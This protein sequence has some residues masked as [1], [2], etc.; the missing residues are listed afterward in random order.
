MQI[1]GRLGFLEGT[2][3]I[4]VNTILFLLKLLV[5][6]RLGSVAMVADAW[7][8]LSDML[9]SFV[10]ILGFWIASTRAD[11]RHPFGHGRAELV[12]SV[13]IATLLGVVGVN[14]LHESAVRLMARKAV[15]FSL[16]ALVVFGVS[17]VVK[18]ALARFS[19]WA[20]KQ[21]NSLSLAADGW[22]HRSD[23]AA[24][25]FIVI[26]AV[27]GLKFWWMDAVL[28]IGVSLLI[29]H[30][31]FDILRSSASSLLGEAH[32][33]D[34]ENRLNAIVQKHLS[35]DSSVHHIH[36]HRYGNHSE[37]SFHVRMPSDTHLL[38]SHEKISAI[39]K[40]VNSTLS[41]EATIHTEPLSLP[42]E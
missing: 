32:D 1:A 2:V 15:A 27:L 17:A 39:E 19:F 36:V 41:M 26:G 22:H 25:L 20:G 40:D 38:E 16:Q 42:R 29:L 10:V 14:F 12:A 3:S 31:A 11:K 4:V 30:A 28:G 8:T 34:L 7:H 37:V 6:L 24:S 23:A 35:P 5:G 13:I 18:E 33:P 21:T 9:T